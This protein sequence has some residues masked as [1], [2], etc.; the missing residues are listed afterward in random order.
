[1]TTTDPAPLPA[2]HRGRRRLSG[3]VFAAIVT[4]SATAS[5]SSEVRAP[6]LPGPSL[7]ADRERAASAARRNEACEACHADIA[8]EWRG[9]HHRSAFTDLAFQ[10]ALA[11]EP[12]AFCR[13]CHAPEAPPESPPPPEL[14]AIGVACVTCH[15]AGD[16]LLAPPKDASSAAPHA[17]LRSQAFATKEACAG[18]HEFD[19][20]DAALR[21]APAPEARPAAP[22]KMQLTLAEHAAS[23]YAEAA[24][25]GC[26]MPFVG[27]GRGRHRSHAFASSRDP[28]AQA[29]A[30]SIS[31][32]R[33][34]AT[35]EIE[36]AP[37]EVG[38]AFPTGDLFRRLAVTAEVVGEDGAL[39]ASQTRFLARHYRPVA[40]P[41]GHKARA[42]VQDDRPG[43]PALEGEPARVSFDFG[44]AAASRS[45]F[46]RVVYQRVAH[47]ADG[48]EAA[49]AV[50]S[51]VTLLERE[52]PAAALD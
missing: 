7:G 11:V 15:I 17:S 26:H 28:L 27:E 29:N 45:I 43:A 24:C 2:S 51:E 46:V 31:A 40:L 22:E 47:A 33:L 38:H 25:A 39:L 20:P 44:S 32:T 34:G 10:G 50:E 5:L 23:A 13:G 16:A 37:G 48:Q 41:G 4:A 12:L 9:S 30:L 35:I 14:A 18:C 3:L 1:M 8:A 6:L 21:P 19:F 49:A 42:A 52:L 36:L